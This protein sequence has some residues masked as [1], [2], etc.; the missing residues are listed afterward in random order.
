MKRGFF[1]ALKS[2]AGKQD[3]EQRS[4]DRE[5][6]LVELAE[7]D[8]A[9]QAALVRGDETSIAHLHDKQSQIKKAIDRLERPWAY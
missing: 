9:L 3:A 7:T 1:D 6:L 8:R 2:G 4:I 5:I